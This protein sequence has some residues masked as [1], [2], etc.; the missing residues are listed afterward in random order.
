MANIQVT[1]DHTADWW[2]G[3]LDDD[4]FNALEAALQDEWG[5]DPLHIREG[6]VSNYSS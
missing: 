3:Q 2:L 4:W 6:G 5:I 1:I